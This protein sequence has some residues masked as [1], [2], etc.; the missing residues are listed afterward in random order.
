MSN[1]LN[2]TSKTPARIRFA[3]LMVRFRVTVRRAFG[4][5]NNGKFESL[6]LLMFITLFAMTQLH[7]KAIY[8]ESRIWVEASMV[9]GPFIFL[10][11]LA[12]WVT[13]VKNG[14]SSVLLAGSGVFASSGW[15]LL[16]TGY[17]WTLQIIVSGLL[18]TVLLGIPYWHRLGNQRNELRKAA[19]TKHIY[20]AP[21]T[22]APTGPFDGVSFLKGAQWVGEP[23]A[24]KTGTR[25]RLVIPN[26]ADLRDFI[27]KRAPGIANVVRTDPDNVE[28]VEV[29]GTGDTLD[30]LVHERNAL[31][32]VRSW[33]LIGASRLNFLDPIPV[34]I[35]RD[36]ELISISLAERH[37]LIGGEPGSGKSNLQAL[38]VAVAV[39]DPHTD[40]Y[41]LDGKRTELWPWRR[42]AK[43]YVDD[44]VRRANELLSRLQDELSRRQ[45]VMREMR[46]RKFTETNGALGPMVLVLDE[47]AAYLK[48][49]RDLGNEFETRLQDLLN[50]GRSAGLIIVA[51]TQFPSSDLMKTDTRRGFT[52]RVAFRVVDT[53]GSEMILGRRYPDASTIDE[54]LR[55]LAFLGA[56]AQPRLIRTF[57]ITDAELYELAETTPPPP[58][59]TAEVVVEEDEDFVVGELTSAAT[60]STGP[61]FPDGTPS[62]RTVPSSG[63]PWTPPPGP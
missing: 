42:H 29:R 56:T 31:E 25:R 55:G 59:I 43:I 35:R 41:L 52:Y 62:R 13:L 34:G 4:M 14:K 60:A 30:V 12:A 2:K 19:V 11:A 18:L 46:A 48:R 20:P 33:P 38:L 39:K 53:D 24:T 61:T 16:A 54:N 57:Y 10:G 21:E 3:Q 9:Y 51:A 58:V 1:D 5:F 50:R 63:R 23:L 17:G 36:D 37:V 49:D 45:D 47:L 27:A 32:A 15:M 26:G 28:L 6:P 8:P 7:R 22:P 44:D 40:L